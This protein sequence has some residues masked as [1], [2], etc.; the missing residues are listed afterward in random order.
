MLCKPAVV[1][2]S[3]VVL[4]YLLAWVFYDTIV[5]TFS[6][7]VYKDDEFKAEDMLPTSIGGWF[8]TIVMIM[9]VTGL[10]QFLCQRQYTTAA[11]AI[12]IIFDVV[13]LVVIVFMLMSAPILNH[14]IDTS[15][16]KVK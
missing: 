15:G 11:W 4:S 14:H 3:F 6:Q 2:L 5:K 16:N 1:H 8:I 9:L 12:T 13:P 10:L 7:G